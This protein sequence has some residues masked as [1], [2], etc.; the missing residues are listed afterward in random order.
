LTCFSTTGLIAALLEPL[1]FKK[2]LK[3]VEVFLGLLTLGGIAIIYAG[4]VQFSIGIIL[5]LASAATLVLVSLFNKKNVVKYGAM[6][7]TLYQL[8]GGFIGLSLL[9]PLYNSFV[10][11]SFALP[12]G[13]DWLWLL[14]L[15]WLC[16]ILAFMF[17]M[18]ALKKVSVFT[19]NLTLTL[20]PVYGI[21]LAFAIFHE[22]E[23]LSWYFYP[24]IMLILLAVVL[25]MLILVKQNKKAVTEMPV[26]NIAV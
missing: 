15:S 3:P 6:Q 20:E 4:N 17:S 2:P 22:N 8:S 13:I 11:S 18:N 9:M 24:G 7:I 14:A 23:N 12:R 25:Q 10:H 1:F 16:T 5:G 19:L 26:E 21:I